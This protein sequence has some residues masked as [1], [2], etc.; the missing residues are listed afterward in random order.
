[1]HELSLAENVLQII[2]DAARAQGFRRVRTV[3]LEIGSL[4]AVEPGAMRFCFDAVV[5]DS[6]AEG[7]ELEIVEIGGAGRCAHCHAEAPMMDWLELCPQC[8]THRLEA[9]RGTSMRVRDLE[10]E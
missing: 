2:E 10:V 7:A 5:R 3:T 1:M 9:I 6:C 8:G 4:A